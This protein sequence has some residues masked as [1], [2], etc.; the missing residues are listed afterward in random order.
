MIALEIA[1]IS[2]VPA[3]LA[4]NSAVPRIQTFDG[5]MQMSPNRYLMWRVRPAE[6]WLD[7]AIVR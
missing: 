6:T 4:G 7:Q 1:P 2:G 3:L 5:V